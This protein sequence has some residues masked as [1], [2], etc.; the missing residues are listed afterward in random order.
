[1]HR[2]RVVTSWSKENTIHKVAE[3][4]VAG[5]SML[6]MSMQLCNKFSFMAS[7]A[8]DVVVAG[9][10]AVVVAGVA[11]VLLKS[12]EINAEDYESSIFCAFDDRL[13]AIVR[14]C[15]RKNGDDHDDHDATAQSHQQKQ[16][17]QQQQ[18]HNLINNNSC[19]NNNNNNCEN[20]N[21]NINQKIFFIKCI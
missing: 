6:C 1:M 14:N 8:V 16:L 20:I 15:H 3:V 18:Q 13:V 11:Y 10:A 19:N 21:R 9:A 5:L 2:Q 4:I 7:D 12:R 17:Q